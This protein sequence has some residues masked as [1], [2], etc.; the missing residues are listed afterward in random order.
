MAPKAPTAYF[1]FTETNR[2]AVQQE[3]NDAA[4][5]AA[6]E[7]HQQQ[8]QDGG[9]GGSAAAGEPARTKVSVAVVAKE[10]GARW[11]ALPEEEKERYKQLAKQRSE[12]L[13]AAAAAE[14]AHCGEA[15]GG[16]GGVGAD[17]SQ[18][19]EADQDQEDSQQAAPGLP[20]GVVKRIMA[21][22]AEFKR[23]SADAVWLIGA[24]AE[25]LLA[26]VA[27]R[28]ARQALSKRR[29]TVKLEDLQHVVKCGGLY[30]GAGTAGF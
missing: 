15:G 30:R 4:A 13:A 16:G 26:L 18:G 3:L 20:R 2:A 11:R 12:A 7:Q 24:A 5:A 27:E 28:A 29:R 19:Q 22:D 17:A 14:A 25:A 6:A 1:I 21:C 9:G 10:L 8:Q 23:A